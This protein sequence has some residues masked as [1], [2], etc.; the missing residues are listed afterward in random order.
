MRRLVSL[1]LTWLA[2]SLLA[3]G[4]K[5]DP[6]PPIIEVPETTTDLA[7]RQVGSEAVLSWSYP[8]LTRAGNPL[9]D[10]ARVEVWRLAV[11]PGQEQGT[12][13]PG[14]EDLRRQ[15][16]LA[17]GVLVG[18]LE[19]KGI[20]SAT[21][22]SKLTYRDSL[23]PVAAPSVPSS[24]WYA[25]RSRRRDG[26]P[27]SLS[28]IVEWQPRPLPPAVTGLTAVAR[29]EGI[30]LRWQPVIGATYDVERRTATG[31]A[32]QSTSGAPVDG[33]EYTDRGATQGRTWSYRVTAVIAG[34]WG[35]PSSEVSV[36]YRDIYPP[37][38]IQGLICLP[39][40]HAVQLRWDPLG[41]AGVHYKVFRRSSGGWEHLVEDTT[42]TEF[43]D[44]APPSG[45]I[46][47]AVKAMDAQGNQS[48]DVRCLVRLGR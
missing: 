48:R 9:S 47:Y 33:S 22:G 8:Q 46:E 42:A 3:C 41:E 29:A 26:T 21:R 25:V 30:T 38:A 35:P 17:R 23:P 39:D 24:F 7:V 4:K 43:V 37:A 12:S 6:L 40:P 18:K 44:S 45:E 16:M 11:P 34:V 36:D 10:L 19:G 14:A 5:A 31:G 15:L 20:E 1:S 13:A 32:W 28:N 27:S 2:V